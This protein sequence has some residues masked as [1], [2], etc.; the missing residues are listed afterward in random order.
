MYGVSILPATGAG[1]SLAM[2]SQTS[3]MSL[4]LLLLAVWTLIAAV[5]TGIRLVPKS[6][7]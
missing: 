7:A 3:S 4:L 6:E 2:I 5:K 1:L